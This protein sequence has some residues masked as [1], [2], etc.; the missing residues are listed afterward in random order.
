MSALVPDVELLRA[1]FYGELPPEEEGEV[2][3]W[4]IIHAGPEVLTVCDEI[5][6]ERDRRRELLASFVAHPLRA[7]L[8]RAFWQARSRLGTRLA[9]LVEIDRE[10]QLALAPLNSPPIEE[11]IIQASLEQPIDLR[12]KLSEPCHVG[13]YAIESW[14]KLSV[15][16]RSEGV[17]Q[18]GRSLELPGLILERQEDVLDL[19][20]I[21]DTAT[22]PPLPHE[23]SPEWLARM[24]QRMAASPTTWV[25]R[26]TLVPAGT[27]R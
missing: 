6:A 9:S 1:Y 18:A 8:E 15:L 23:E 19:Y 10:R 20:L 11:L 16:W 3:R 21:L 2:R 27:A 14:S 5:V 22:P 4:L 25:L 24:L 26:R 13:V 12:L 17:L 7:K